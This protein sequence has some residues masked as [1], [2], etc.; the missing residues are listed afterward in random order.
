M[1]QNIKSEESKKGI[2][3]RCGNNIVADGLVCPF[4]N[5]FEVYKD[6]NDIENTNKWFFMIRAFR[7]DNSSHCTNCD[8]WFEV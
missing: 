4:C 6:G 2:I 8:K 7:V 1:L 3:S 5:S